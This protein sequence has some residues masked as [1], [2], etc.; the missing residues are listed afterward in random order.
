MRDL[1]SVRTCLY[2]NYTQYIIAGFNGAHNS[3]VEADDRAVEVAAFDIALHKRESGKH[4][5]SSLCSLPS[6]PPPV[7]C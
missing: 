3:V 4:G 6:G 7:F 1:V 2:T 5:H